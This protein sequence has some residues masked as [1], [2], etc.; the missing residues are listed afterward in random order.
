MTLRNAPV[1]EVA[2]ATGA[3][4]LLLPSEANDI[5]AVRVFFPRGSA[6]DSWETAGLTR[7][8]LKCLLRGT[9]K[10]SQAEFA[11]AVESLGT[12]LS[13][14][15]HH[16]FSVASLVATAETL[17][18]SL[19]LLLEAL[20]EPA[21]DPAEIDKQREITLA[22]IREELDDKGAFAGRV[23]AETLHG[24]HS[25]GIPRRG[26]L[27]SVSRFSPDQVR[28]QYSR[29]VTWRNALVVAVG[30]FAPEDL[31]AVFDNAPALS[32]HPEAGRPLVVTPTYQKGAVVELA[33]DWEQ[34]YLILGFPACPLS[35]PDYFRLRLLAGVLGDGMSS[36]FFVRLRDERGL[37][38][39]TGCS[40]QAWKAGGYLAGFIG[41]KPASVDEARELMLRLFSEVCQE[42]VP[43]DELERTKNYLVGK[44]LIGHQRNA[45]R[46]Y[47]LGLYE[48]LGLA[49]HLD[50]DYPNRIRSVSADEV[51]EVA[52]QYLDMP[53]VVEI[54]PEQSPPAGV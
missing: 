54:R 33:R 1:H 53:T 20:S 31:K 18:P 17:A 36:R 50:E 12:S 41:T 23:F 14:S 27:E 10:R 30:K 48:M 25:Y 3:R 34:A 13:F 2:F 22:A 5:V 32:T 6:S 49:W 51:L 24:R 26:T 42:K 4:G 29:V 37:A 46:A 52:Q 28:M 11:E 9:L 47:Y 39:A 44:Y 16:D 43:Y 21:F 19:E 8:M 35:H 40:L 15:A 45:D 7:F 38:Y